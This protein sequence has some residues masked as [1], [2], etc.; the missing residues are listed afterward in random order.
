[1][2]LEKARRA[3]K[4]PENVVEKIQV[5]RVRARTGITLVVGPDATED[6]AERLRSEMDAWQAARD[7]ALTN[8]EAS[9]SE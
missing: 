2:V 9:L 3:A 5:F 7:E 1:M 4:N 6:D 8:T